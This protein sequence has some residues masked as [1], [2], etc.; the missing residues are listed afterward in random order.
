MA[1]GS[2]HGVGSR[3][4]PAKAHEYDPREG[5]FSRETLP[6]DLT[7]YLVRCYKP[8]SSEMVFPCTGRIRVD[9]DSVHRVFDLPNRGQKVIYVVDKDATRRF[10]E[11]FNIT[12]N[13]HPS[14]IAFNT[15]LAPTT[16]LKLRPKCYGLVLDHE[17]LKNTNICLF[18][19]EHI[20]EAF[21]NMDHDK[22]TVKHAPQRKRRVASRQEEE[23]EFVEEDD[24]METEQDFE[25]EDKEDEE[26]EKDKEEEE[27][28]EE[29]KE[30][31]EEEEE[32]KEEVEEEEEE[33]K[34]EEEDR[35][36]DGDIDARLDGNDSA[37]DDDDEE[38]EDVDR[39]DQG[40]EGGDINRGDDNDD[41]G[42]G[43]GGIGGNTTRGA[44][45]TDNP[46][47]SSNSMNS[48]STLQMWMDKT[49]WKDED[50]PK[51]KKNDE[52]LSHEGID[53]FKLC[54]L[55]TV[56]PTPFHVP[57]FHL[58]EMFEKTN[59]AVEQQIPEPRRGKREATF[60]ANLPMIHKCKT[61]SMK[62]NLK[63]PETKQP[64]LW[65]DAEINSEKETTSA[66]DLAPT[67]VRREP[68]TTEQGQLSM[69]SLQLSQKFNTSRGRPLYQ[70]Y[71]LN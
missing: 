60:V 31:D 69:L 71:H 37:G 2:V 16:S 21:R 20:N 29:E 56:L 26:E 61:L 36:V 8:E 10:G 40:K 39:D 57:D 46:D 19:A 47:S 15:F 30:E 9:A 41:R 28:E 67:A 70:R 12:G 33:E 25:D 68:N 27:D 54:N 44:S 35:E 64:V 1:Q 58:Q 34:E 66:A 55:K 5:P 6:T 42:P 17:M 49:C 14:I 65:E 23:D 24:E 59:F 63:L 52:P 53:M 45:S 50:F 4:L 43:S 62:K 18:V 51:S 38:D 22:Q 11:T 32:D 48:K 13:S 3:M 7:K